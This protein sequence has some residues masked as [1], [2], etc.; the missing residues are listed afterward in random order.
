MSEKSLHF[1]NFIHKWSK[2]MDYLWILQPSTAL[3]DQFRNF[4]NQVEISLIKN[5]YFRLK[6]QFLEHQCT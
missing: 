4:L 6:I 1:V 2:K 3:A 5:T